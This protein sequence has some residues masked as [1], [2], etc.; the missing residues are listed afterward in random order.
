MET[1]TVK[2][3]K[4]FIEHFPDEG[5]VVFVNTQGQYDIRAIEIKEDTISLKTMMDDQFDIVDSIRDKRQ[6]I[7]NLGL[8]LFF[9]MI[10]A[11]TTSLPYSAL[12]TPWVWTIGSQ[13]VVGLG[14]LLAL[15]LCFMIHL[16]N[17][18]IK[19]LVINKKEFYKNVRKGIQ[20]R[21]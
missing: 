19:S 6:N 7:T 4:K 15:G 17:K 9:M 3:L 18:K 16:D 2:Q 11:L 1:L 10:S 8:L 14:V 5:N 20:N 12:L 13:I 21:K